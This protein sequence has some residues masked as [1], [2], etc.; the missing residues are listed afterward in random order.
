MNYRSVV[1]VLIAVTPLLAVHNSA[2]I[3]KYVSN[4]GEYDFMTRLDEYGA[5]PE[6]DGFEL[7]GDLIARQMP[8]GFGIGDVAMDLG[9]DDDFFAG[10]FEPEVPAQPTLAEA[11]ADFRDAT[12]IDV[13]RMWRKH[14]VG[15]D[16]WQLLRTVAGTPKRAPVM[17]ERPVKSPFL[18]SSQ[19][20]GRREF[21]IERNT[22]IHQKR[23]IERQAEQEVKQSF[24]DDITMGHYRIVDN[25]GLV[26][27]V[28]VTAKDL[29]KGPMRATESSD[30][31]V[32]EQ[33]DRKIYF[34]RLKSP[35]ANRPLQLIQVLEEWIVRANQEYLAPMIRTMAWNGLQLYD[36][37]VNI[38][39]M[40]NRALKMYE[41]VD[42]RLE[43]TARVSSKPESNKSGASKLR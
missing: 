10:W 22:E 14:I 29:K 19:K 9:V 13:N 38:R 11:W 7:P 27:E 40:A 25:L 21:Q 1:F 39:S 3:Q 6:W 20:T 8:E 23:E 4:G 28:V 34:V 43:S 31:Y 16:G 12:G 37:E 17:A 30:Y 42:Q 2:Q 5:R 41:M 35:V 32:L 15:R 36:A 33:G 26:T 18:F 24:P